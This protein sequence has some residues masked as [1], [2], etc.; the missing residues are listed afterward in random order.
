MPTYKTQKPPLN[1]RLWAALLNSATSK[2]NPQTQQ[3]I[4]NP[5]SITEGIGAGFRGMGEQIQGRMT[6]PVA[7]M[8]QGGQNFMSGVMGTQPPPQAMP[9]PA[10][11]PE[12]TQAATGTTQPEIDQTSKVEQFIKQHGDAKKRDEQRAKWI[13]SAV[14][15]GIPLGAAIAGSINPG[16]LPEM[17][18][19]AT[20]SNKG[21]ERSEDFGLEEDKLDVA[22]ENIEYEKGQDLEARADKL[23][24]A[25]Y[26]GL[27][28]ATPPSQ[29]E[30]METRQM[31]LDRLKGTKTETKKK[32]S[33]GEK[34]TRG[35]H[36]YEVIGGDLEND[37]DIRKI[38]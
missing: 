21:F 27:V 26:E 35:G 29:D 4:L 20:G 36:E 13:Q 12:P 7:P 11:Q 10:P 8:V 32:Y 2:M 17:S 19:L 30:L 24:S 18:G 34:I 15:L 33:V 38:K 1:E 9:Q 14:R 28:S 22:K 25:M 23:V 31:I 5:S 6:A 37:P 3:R 16:I